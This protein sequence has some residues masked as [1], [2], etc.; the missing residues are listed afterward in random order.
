M[1]EEVLETALVLME[2]PPFSMLTLHGT[3]QDEFQ[4]VFR[5]R[6]ASVLRKSEAVIDTLLNV[7][8]PSADLFERTGDTFGASYGY[9]SA[10]CSLV[11]LASAMGPDWKPHDVVKELMRLQAVGELQFTAAAKPHFHLTLLPPPLSITSTSTEGDE[12]APA[13]AA[14][15]SSTPFSPKRIGE[16]VAALAERMAAIEVASVKKVEQVYSVLRAAAGAPDEEGQEAQTLKL[17]DAY[18]AKKDLPLPLN[19]P[20]PFAPAIPSQVQVVMRR[21]AN[22]LLLDPRLVLLLQQVVGRSR[23]PGAPTNANLEMELRLY[24]ARLATRVF[25]GIGSPRLPLM[26]W[27]ESPFWGKHCQYKFEDVESALSVGEG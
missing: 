20:M 22:T 16:V 17:I 11:R 6:Q 1:R 3:V 25:H 24:K 4:V 21:D 18:F 15:A 26:E 14:A 2:L 13:A 19:I 9:G 27:R 5:K 12:A 8:T 10:A 7:G 23:R